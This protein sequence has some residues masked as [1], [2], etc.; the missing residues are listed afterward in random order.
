M[1]QQHRRCG[2]M[3]QRS[4]ARD[5]RGNS[6][7]L[8]RRQAA[9]IDQYE[10][11]QRQQHDHPGEQIGLGNSEMDEDS[12]AAREQQSARQGRTKGQAEGDQQQE[13]GCRK[14]STRQRCGDKPA[15][16][17]RNAN[18]LL[19]AHHRREIIARQKML[20]LADDVE[21]ARLHA[22]AEFL[23]IGTEQTVFD[24]DA[25]RDGGQALKGTGAAEQEQQRG[26]QRD[27]P[28]TGH[29]FPSSL[30]AQ[31]GNPESCRAAPGL[32]RWARNDGRIV[33]CAITLTPSQP[34]EQPP[35]PAPPPHRARSTVRQ[36]HIDRQKPRR[37]CP[38][39]SP[40]H[41]RRAFRHG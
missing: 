39:A 10:R 3:R 9:A 29:Q 33:Q 40:R 2:Q 8:Q 15:L 23:R 4:D 41:A 13:R 17:R 19:P 28:R 36:T 16:P 7:S 38:P 31:R 12:V 21:R 5:Q 24:R 11:Q 22:G 14:R 27:K 30:R 18:R 37:S 32:P 1:H 26:D 25:V 35:R 6:S 34:R 20:L